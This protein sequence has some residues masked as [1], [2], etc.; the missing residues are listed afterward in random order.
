MVCNY[1][2][3]P[4]HIIPKCQRRPQNRNTAV[5]HATTSDTSSSSASATVMHT[6]SP[7]TPTQPTPHTPAQPNITLEMIQK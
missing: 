7:P 3:K 6:Q 1:C 2:R 5:Y 4:G